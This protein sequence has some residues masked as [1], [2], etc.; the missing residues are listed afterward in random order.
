MG[1]YSFKRAARVS[2]NTSDCGSPAPSHSSL[3]SCFGLFPCLKE[4]F[5]KST[6]MSMM[7]TLLR[8]SLTFADWDTG[9]FGRVRL[10]HQVV[11][12]LTRGIS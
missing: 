5:D 12:A 4:L 9:A 8:H 6:E 11:K 10:C 1:F 2:E 3:K 7:D